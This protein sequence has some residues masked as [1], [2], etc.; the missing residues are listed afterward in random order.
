MESKSIAL[1]ELQKMYAI[2]GSQPPGYQGL[3]R[4]KIV[5]CP[6][7]KA[8]TKETGEVTYCSRHFVVAVIR[9]SP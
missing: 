1:G 9:E 3:P 5:L 4:G 8:K 7:C 6:E 2:C